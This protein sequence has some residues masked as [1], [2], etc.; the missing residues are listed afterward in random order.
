VSGNG[1]NG[2][3]FGATITTDRFS[4]NTAY[5]FNGSSYIRVN[6]SPLINFGTGSFTLSCWVLSTGSN[7]WQHFITHTE[8]TSTPYSSKG[9][10]LRYDN[11]Q[12]TYIQGNTFNNTGFG[13]Q[14]PAIAANSWHHIVSVYN[15]S[16]LTVSIYVDGA[17][18]RTENIPTPL[19]NVDNNGF[20]YLGVENP[21]VSLPSGPQFLT[22]KLDDIGI[23]SR[24][25]TSCEITQL[26]NT[27]TT[28]VPPLGS[29]TFNPL[30]DTSRAC[31]TNTV[32][33]AGSYASCS[34]NTG[35]TAQTITAT[36][37]GFYK[38]TVTNTAG[39]TA[40]DSTYL[41]LVNANILNNDTTIC[42]GSSIRLTIDSLFPNRT[43]CSSA[44]LPEAMK[45]GLLAYYPFCG[46]ANN[47]LGAGN[48][49]TIY[50]AT[51]TTDRFGNA[52]SAYNFN[53]TN[54]YIDFGANPAI[55]PTSTIPTSISLWVSGG[56][57]GNIISKYTNLDASRS[58]FFFG[59][60]GR[61]CRF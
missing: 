59:R 18:A 41:S 13:A 29:F 22:G 27:N 31:G 39:C 4:G 53:G 45:N 7:R 25:L 56:A 14:A 1:L 58:Y 20:L 52:N 40:S 44:Q 54:A 38:V 8:P 50:N 21:V 3:V 9:Y 26:F 17:L 24:A 35:S 28:T 10:A 46:N 61:R 30:S 36:S 49:G 11:N 19:Q 60:S 51:L 42:L 48:N 55:G 6:N 33:N 47:A 37:S 5:S 2:T 16:T 43:A 34:W 23:W 57:S 12:P 15:A 32:L